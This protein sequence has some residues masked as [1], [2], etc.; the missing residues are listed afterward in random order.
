MIDSNYF[1]STMFHYRLWGAISRVSHIVDTFYLAGN[2][3][4]H[5]D[6][7]IQYVNEFIKNFKCCPQLTAKRRK[8][9]Y[10]KSIFLSYVR[11]TLSTAAVKL[12]VFY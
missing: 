11:T 5:I 10:T 2:M 12:E 8:T 7:Q 9:K 1:G 6:S 3:S 4:T